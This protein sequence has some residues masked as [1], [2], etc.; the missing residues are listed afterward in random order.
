MDS[1]RTVSS[2]IFTKDITL[3]LPNFPLFLEAIARRIFASVAVVNLITICQAQRPGCVFWPTGEGLKSNTVIAFLNFQ[4][5]VGLPVMNIE[6]QTYPDRPLLCLFTN[7]RAR[8]LIDVSKKWTIQ[9]NRGSL[10]ATGKKQ[11]RQA[12][13]FAT[14]GK[15]IYW[16]TIEINIFK[17]NLWNA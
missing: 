13:G 8:H 9:N 4:A 1:S 5:H 14:C 7:S 11:Q 12:S 15:T 17:V 10:P 16:N 2:I 3:A 6:E